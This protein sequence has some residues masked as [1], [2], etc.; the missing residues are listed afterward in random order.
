ML[1][2][3]FSN[4]CKTKCHIRLFLRAWNTK[5]LFGRRNQNRNTSFTRY[6]MGCS[7]IECSLA[8]SR[9]NFILENGIITTKSVDWL[10]FSLGT[11]SKSNPSW[12]NFRTSLQSWLLWEFY[13]IIIFRQLY[14]GRKEK[15]IE[16]PTISI[17]TTPGGTSIIDE[18]FKQYFVICTHLPSQL[19]HSDP[20]FV[21]WLSVAGKY[22]PP[23]APPLGQLG[24]RDFGFLFS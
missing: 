6:L 18:G 15:V 1:R 17:Y 8:E 3:C 7:K 14:F 20:G 4:F 13:S 22:D 23:S 11:T 10:Y 24:L 19:T 5:Y 2:T 9:K 21:T 12:T 16:R